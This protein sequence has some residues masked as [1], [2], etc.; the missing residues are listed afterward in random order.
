MNSATGKVVICPQLE[1]NGKR[2][3]TTGL[4]ILEVQGLNNATALVVIEEVIPKTQD[5]IK[6]GFIL[7]YAKMKLETSETITRKGML[8]SFEDSH[9]WSQLEMSKKW[10]I[11]DEQRQ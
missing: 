1:Y 11:I 3:A 10:D 6:Y 5:S 8:N 9:F 4:D 2:H 7:D